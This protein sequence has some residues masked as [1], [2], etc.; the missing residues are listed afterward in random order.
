MF[1]IKQ[2]EKIT[3][4]LA[5]IH[6]RLAREK[7]IADVLKTRDDVNWEV[8]AWVQD[9]S[10]KFENCKKDIDELKEYLMEI[11]KEENNGVNTEKN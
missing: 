10:F 3:K 2:K 5:R 8:K 6:R 9:I 7:H 4:L 11:N 1:T